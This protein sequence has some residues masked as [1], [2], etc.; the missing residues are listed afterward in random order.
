MSRGVGLQLD[1]VAA[2][3]KFF[4]VH[5]EGQRRPEDPESFTFIGVERLLRGKGH[6]S[7]ESI[8]GEVDEG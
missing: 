1:M 3:I 5:L 8:V 4:S 6:G 2:E 7:E